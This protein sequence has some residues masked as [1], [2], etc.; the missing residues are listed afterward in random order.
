MQNIIFL[1]G[2]KIKNMSVL[3][4]YL[5]VL[6][7]LLQGY[8]VQKYFL[9]LINT[10]SRPNKPKVPVTVIIC[11]KNEENNLARNLGHVLRQK[12][13]EFEVLVLDDH[14]TDDTKKV[15]ESFQ[16]QFSHLTYIQASQEIKNKEG[17]KW[18]ISEAIKFAKYDHLLFTDA[19]CRPSSLIWIEEM[20]ARLSAKTD[21]VLGVGHYYHTNRFYNRLIQYETL[22]TA[23]QY[24]GMSLA[25]QPYM[26]V[27][28][29]LAY[30]RS[31]FN[32]DLMKSEDI[33]SGD[34]DLFLQKV[35]T[36]ENTDICINVKANT[37]SASPTSY[38]AWLWQKRRHNSAGKYYSK[39][40]LRR[41]T[42]VKLSFYLPNYLF[43]ILLFLDFHAS[44]CVFL[45]LSRWLIWTVALQ[46]IRWKLGF[47]QPFYLLP[48]YEIY[49]SLF[50][51]WMM[52]KNLTNN[53]INW[54]ER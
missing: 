20:M 19:D 47:S 34:D 22:F 11:A 23:L 44:W 43:L 15:I 38:S 54:S 18:A 45:F 36:G 27:G 46:K 24:L 50:D 10:D 7:L 32:E 28:R 5:F 53:K 25:G 39:K 13:E 37:Y 16:E 1:G 8:Y 35:M 6:F 33:A 17:K 31:V 52:F 29:N 40:I 51:G 49:F 42:A 14:S 26:G 4:W 9:P 30:K 3:L 21:I 12:Y 48:C 41:L 2:R